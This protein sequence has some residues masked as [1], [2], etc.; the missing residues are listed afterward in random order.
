MSSLVKNIRTLT[1]PK[2]TGSSLSQNV[3]S[4]KLGELSSERQIE[5]T[6]VLTVKELSSII[7]SHFHQ[8]E[9]TLLSMNV[10]T[11]NSPSAPLSRRTCG[12][13]FACCPHRYSPSRSI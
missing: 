4:A 12:H 1:I 9:V 7:P 6:R 5:S 8:C 10:Q 13:R 2:V 11:R 3:T